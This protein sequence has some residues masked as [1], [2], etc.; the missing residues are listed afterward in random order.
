MPTYRIYYV[1]REAGARG[2][3]GG[4][5]PYN[6]RY[7]YADSMTGRDPLRESEWGEDVEAAS[8]SAALDAF[9]QARVRDNSE[10]MWVD[11]EGNTQPVQGLNYDPALKYIWIEDGKLME[12]RDIEEAKAGSVICPLCDGAGE[13]DEEVAAEFLADY[14]SDGEEE[15]G[16]R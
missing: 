2:G 8:P 12:Y 6:P 9:F 14:E 10:L 15:A 4:L 13:V 3:I 1:E 7:H 5:H 11:D 16:Y